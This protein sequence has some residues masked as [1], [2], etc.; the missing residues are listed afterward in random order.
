MHHACAVEQHIQR[1][2]LVGQALNGGGIGDVQNN[3]V[4]ACEG[5]EG[6]SIDVG[7]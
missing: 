1:A 2:K 6:A 3:F 4:S 5:L 7:G